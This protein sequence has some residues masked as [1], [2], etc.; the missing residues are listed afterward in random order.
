M[1]YYN[2]YSTPIF[3]KTINEMKDI[4][5]YKTNTCRFENYLQ[6]GIGSVATIG[7]ILALPLLRN[8]SRFTISGL[9]IIGGFYMLKNSIQTIIK[10]NSYLPLN[11]ND[12]KK[13]SYI[14]SKINKL[15]PNSVGP[16]L[17]LIPEIQKFT[18]NDEFTNLLKIYYEEYKNYEKI[19]GILYVSSFDFKRFQSKILTL[20]FSD[21]FK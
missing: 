10:H 19:P 3:P 21:D 17:D 16:V 1:A 15:Q 2:T 9:S 8:K 5:Y 13:Y 12:K 14:F 18:T 20:L 11:D 6:F 7:G 4:Y